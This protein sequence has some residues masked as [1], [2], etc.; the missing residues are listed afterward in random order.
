MKKVLKFIKDT[1]KNI[2]F[3]SKRTWVLFGLLIMIGLLS[4]LYGS[5]G[6]YLNSGTKN[7]V[8][9]G[10]ASF[11][12]ADLTLQIYLQD[13]DSSGNAISNSYSRAYYIPQANYTYESAKTVCGTGI[14]LTY[15]STNYE[16]TINSTQKGICKVYF[17]AE[18]TAVPNA[19]YGLNV[20]QSIDSS[21]YV[22]MGSLP[23][24]DYV[25]RAN[26]TMTTCTDPN[27]QVSIVN[28]RIMIESSTDTDCNIYADVVSLTG[29]LKTNT[30][31]YTTFSGITTMQQM[32]SFICEYETTPEVGATDITWDHTL[33][34]SKVP[35]TVLTDT[36]DGKKYLV[37]KLADGNCWMS[38]NLAF[39]LDQN[40]SIRSI[41]TDLNTTTS[42]TPYHSTQT[43]TGIT[44]SDYG[45]SG[46]ESYHPG[47]SEAYYKGGNVL[48]STP[49]GSADEY[50][51]ESAGN[52]Y[53]WNASTAG[54]GI[55]N[56][57][58]TSVDDSICPIGWQLPSNS[59]DK[60]FYHLITEIYGFTSSS[61]SSTA[62]RSNPF[63]FILAGH[64]VHT[65]GEMSNQTTNA[66]YW[67]NTAYT[68]AA[69]AYHLYMTS[70]S[71]ST[72]NSNNKGFGYS[73]RCVAR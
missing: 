34:T 16:F 35:R 69:Y 70:S 7:V 26:D 20:E 58:N 67:T 37:T 33:D 32:T 60:S 17:A 42:W 10:T 8:I 13:R 57:K 53:N 22:K 1:F 66:R 59:G 46:A 40:V 48:S 68:S 15:D 54:S 36:R 14:T 5:Y 55:W 19:S 43:E 56:V 27:A 30:P 41:D 29:G 47:S 64:Y 23:N 38:Q 21:K 51:W 72:Q 2:D 24:N 9:S 52:Y 28:N 62:L 49:T 45:Q 65:S 18:G 61:T 25:F 73:V 6:Y 39:D 12:G 63:N 50:L 4:S 3:K 44:W 31:K 71:I 11:G